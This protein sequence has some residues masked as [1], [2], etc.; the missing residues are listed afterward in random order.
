L[1][2]VAQAYLDE[3]RLGPGLTRRLA[4]RFDRPEPT[5]ATGS[6]QRAAEAFLGPTTPGV[7]VPHRPEPAVRTQQTSRLPD[8]GSD[9][10]GDAQYSDGRRRGVLDA[11][12]SEDAL[13][14]FV[15]SA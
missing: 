7:A 10:H 14:L 4:E 1:I 6:Q 8:T 2:E 11:N 9:A 15:V 12:L 5:S 3:A 13:M